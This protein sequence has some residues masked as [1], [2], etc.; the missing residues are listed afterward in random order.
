MVNHGLDAMRESH[1]E[2]GEQGRAF[3]CPDASSLD[4]PES[5]ACFSDLKLVITPQGNG[6][7][8]W[9]TA[10]LTGKRSQRHG[11]SRLDSLTENPPSSHGKN[12]IYLKK[13]RILPSF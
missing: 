12:K 4:I 8:A 7:R 1:R 2:A 11:R 9:A 10:T 3:A 13:E 5:D 6:C